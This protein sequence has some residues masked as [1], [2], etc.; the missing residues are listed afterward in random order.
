MRTERANEKPLWRIIQIWSPLLVHLCLCLVLC[1]VMVFSVDGYLALATDDQPRLQPDGRFV[2]YVSDI[3]TL[4][5]A[6]LLLI[7]FTVS[8]WTGV[9]LW[10]C[11]YILFE[12]KGLDLVTFSR[13]MTWGLPPT[14]KKHNGG[15]G[16][17]VVI[18]LLCIFPPQF[19]GPLLSGSVN[20]TSGSADGQAVDIRSGAETARD[21]DWYWYLRQQVERKYYVER[22]AGLVSLAWSNLDSNGA[23]KGTNTLGRTCRHVVGQNNQLPVNSSLYNATIPCIDVDNI[24]WP[25]YPISNTSDT[26]ALIASLGRDLSLIG[27]DPFSYYQSGLAILFDPENF[28]WDSDKLYNSGTSKS[29]YFPTEILFHGTMTVVLFLESHLAK[30]YNESHSNDA[31][32]PSVFGDDTLELGKNVFGVLDYD[33]EIRFAHATVNFTA[34]VIQAPT[35]R[36][37]SSRVVEPVERGRATSANDSEYTATLSI[38]PSIWVTEALWLMPDVMTRIALMNSSSIPTWNNLNSY[39]TTLI[40]QAYLANWDMLHAEFEQNDTA[41]LRAVP[42]NQRPIASVSMPRVFAWLTLNLLMTLSGIIVGRIHCKRP[43]IVDPPAAVL[44]T[45]AGE[46]VRRLPELTRLSYVTDKDKRLKIKLVEAQEDSRRFKLELVYDNSDEEELQ[47]LSGGAQDNI[48][49]D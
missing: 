21:T 31:D 11:A 32:H 2:L 44:L 35:S 48:G 37:I 4:I 38:K 5:S 19:I 13:M 33:K 14:K 47:S 8:A 41:I 40:A 46:V 23:S 3:T 36:Y 25:P 15:V 42:R 12:N 29:P 9:T 26:Y 49:G 7:D 39:T 17:A 34:G 6:A 1:V 27:D 16:W 30:G 43:V 45:D 10:R 20:W 28:T 24:T 18:V 22:A